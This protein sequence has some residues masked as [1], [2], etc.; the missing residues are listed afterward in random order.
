M[1]IMA[2]WFSIP[3]WGTALGIIIQPLFIVAGTRVLATTGNGPVSPFANAA[4]FLYGLIRPEEMRA[5][6][7][8][9]HITADAQATGEGNNAAF[10]VAQRIGGSFANLLAVQLLVLPI[11]AII[12]PLAFQAMVDT[13]GIGFDDGQLNAPTGLKIASVAIVMTKGLSALPAGALAWSAI[14]LVFGVTCELLAPRF[15]WLPSTA[16]FGFA[17]ILPPTLTLGLA[18]GSIA[19]AI[20]G[21]FKPEAHAKFCDVTGA[22][23][24]AGESMVGGVLIPLLAVLGLL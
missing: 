20:W 2:S 18:T 3:W 14:A 16:A 24:L 15:R 22:G 11:G 6:L 4:Q 1:I 13:Y 21:R 5:N 19:S 10:W 17:L 9:A 12:V 7:A 23:I 8:Q